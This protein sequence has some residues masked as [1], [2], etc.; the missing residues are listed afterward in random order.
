MMTIA[1]NCGI[2]LNYIIIGGYFDMKKKI[3]S[4]LLVALLI[5]SVAPLGSFAAQGGRSLSLA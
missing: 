1:L 2:I 5:A 3:V 4:A